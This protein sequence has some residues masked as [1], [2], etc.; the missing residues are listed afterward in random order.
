MITYPLTIAGENVELTWT[1][2]TSC[3]MRLRLQESG[4][5]W[6]KDTKGERMGAAMVRICWALLPD[7]VFD[8]YPT[9]HK[10]Y[11]AMSDGEDVEMLKTINQVLS[12]LA[13]SEQK[14]STSTKSR[15]PKSS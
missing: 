9:H 12:E 4:F 14:K 13:P 5:D 8:R 15:S 7:E 1:N 10:M 2:S 3:L 6:I 11:S